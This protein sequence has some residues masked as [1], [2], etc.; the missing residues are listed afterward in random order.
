[1]LFRLDGMGYIRFRSPTES[2]MLA[3]HVIPAN[4]VI[5]SSMIPL[6]EK[7]ATMAMSEK[8]TKLV[9]SMYLCDILVHESAIPSKVP[10]KIPMTSL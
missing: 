8:A 3:A 5:V 4:P 2:G 10:T 6:V 1:M 9:S 7:D